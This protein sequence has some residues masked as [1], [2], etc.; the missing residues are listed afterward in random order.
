VA[1]AYVPERSQVGFDRLHFAGAAPPDPTPEETVAYA[2]QQALSDALEAAHAL[3]G[4]SA[5]PAAFA[6]LLASAQGHLADA[7][8]GAGGLGKPGKKAAKRIRKS[9]Q[10]FTK[11]QG[12]LAGPKPEKGLKSYGKAVKS[13][14]QALDALLPDQTF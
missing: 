6:A 8:A 12:Q 3:D 1:A 7:Q 11:A 10:Q 9:S 2:V 13:A 5:D 4:P 14:A